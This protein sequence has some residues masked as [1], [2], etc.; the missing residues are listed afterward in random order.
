MKGKWNECGILGAI[1][2]QII[3]SGSE[4]SDKNKKVN[5]KEYCLVW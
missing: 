5:Q 2:E 1:L 4:S 3:K